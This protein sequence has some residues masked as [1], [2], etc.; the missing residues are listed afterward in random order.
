MR[1][2][3]LYTLI[4]NFIRYPPATQA[5]LYTG[6]GRSILLYTLNLTCETGLIFLWP[7][8]GRRYGR[9]QQPESKPLQTQVSNSVL[10]G[11]AWAE[12]K[13]SLLCCQGLF[14]CDVSVHRVIQNVFVVKIYLDIRPDNPDF[15]LC[16]ASCRIPDLT[17][18]MSV[19]SSLLF[20]IMAVVFSH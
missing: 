9:R 18:R 2:L 12:V 4:Q 10:W 20:E 3:I 17:T 6:Q 1:F 19:A 7:Q 16:P 15:F 5:G 13:S 11:W 14:F 8:T